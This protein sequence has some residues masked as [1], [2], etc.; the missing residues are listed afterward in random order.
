MNFIYI[1]I[2]K[3]IKYYYI[4]YIALLILNINNKN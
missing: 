2:L 4:L 3:I 1:N